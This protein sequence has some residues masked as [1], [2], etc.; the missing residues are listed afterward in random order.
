M[1]LSCGLFMLRLRFS[2]HPF[3]AQ[4]WVECVTDYKPG[5]S[6]RAG[7]SRHKTQFGEIFLGFSLWQFLAGY[8]INCRASHV[9]YVKLSLINTL[10]FKVLTLVGGILKGLKSTVS[11][12]HKSEMQLS[13]CW[14]AISLKPLNIMFLRELQEKTYPH[15]FLS[16]NIG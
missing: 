7:F 3:N 8:E 11:L 14:S 6:S 16:W 12:E 9:A 15:E 5:C 10:L 1:S 4:K 2:R 13:A